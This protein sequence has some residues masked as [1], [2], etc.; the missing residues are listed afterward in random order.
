MIPV[1]DARLR[2]F[3]VRISLEGENLTP[4]AFAQGVLQTQVSRNTLTVPTPEVR[5]GDGDP[6]VYVAVKDGDDAIVKKRVVK[7]GA[8]ANGKTQIVSG[9]TAGDQVIEGSGLYD[10]GQKIKVAK[11]S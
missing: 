4:G 11:E 3:R 5:T 8:Q 9:L 7:V 1:A 6:Y 10:D 2:Q